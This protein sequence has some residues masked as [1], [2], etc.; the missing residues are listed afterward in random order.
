MVVRKSTLAVECVLPAVLSV[1]R[2]SQSWGKGNP[3]TDTDS[4]VSSKTAYGRTAHTLMPPIHSAMTREEIF[5]Y[6]LQVLLNILSAAEEN[7]L[8]TQLLNS[9]ER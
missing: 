8:A 5:L 3:L 4:L 1:I 9:T 6:I 2:F 7:H